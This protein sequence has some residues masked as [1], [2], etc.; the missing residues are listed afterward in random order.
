MPAH[1]I[2]Y[3]YDSQGMSDQEEGQ[4]SAKFNDWLSGIDKHAIGNAI[5]RVSNT[6]LLSSDDVAAVGKSVAMTGYT[7]LENDDMD[8]V[9]SLAGTC[10]L[11]EIGGVVEVSRTVNILDLW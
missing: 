6:T 7:L 9:L 10:P 5:N 8:A 2:T 4:V 11:L 1:I 3:F